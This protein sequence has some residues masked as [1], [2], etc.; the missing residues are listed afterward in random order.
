MANLL[1]DIRTAKEL[2]YS[3][4]NKYIWQAC[5][6]CGKERWV[7]LVQGEPE[8]PRCRG[9]FQLGDKNPHWKGG[10][11]YFRGYVFVLAPEH[12]KAHKR[13]IKR[14][15]LILE[16]KLGRYLL[17]GHEPHHRNGIK[18]DDHPENLIELPEGDHKALTNRE[19][20]KAEHM[21]KFRHPQ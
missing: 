3:G 17:D 5:V 16:Q 21:R 13:Y 2:G 7:R 19:L 11:Y 18:D 1:G 10:Q 9:C 8:S 15:R 14:A 6:D 12:P 4:S 20:K